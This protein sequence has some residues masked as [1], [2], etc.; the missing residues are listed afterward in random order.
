MRTKRY[1]DACE[2]GSHGETQ[3]VVR[4][5]IAEIRRGAPDAPLAQLVAKLEAW[6]DGR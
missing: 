3:G 5:W 2:P 1:S 6:L 4:R